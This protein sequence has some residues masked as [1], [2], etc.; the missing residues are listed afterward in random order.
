MQL[1]SAVSAITGVSREKVMLLRH[2]NSTVDLFLA[3][4]GTVEEYTAV[5][6]TGS[7]YDYLDPTKT[8]VEAVAVIV[9]DCVHGVFK[10]HGV[11]KEGT[12]FSL[13]STA[14]RRFDE[15]RGKSER[16][17]RRF[18][19][20]A[21]ATPLIGAPVQGWEKRSRTPVQRSDGG[22]FAEIVVEAHFLKPEEHEIRAQLERSV[23]SALRDSPSARRARM[24]SSPSIPIRIEVV[25]TAFLRNPDVIAE[26]L[27]RAAGVCELCGNPAPFNR[28]SDETPYLEVHHRKTLASGGEDTVE[29]AVATCPN[30]HRREH[31]GYL[32]VQALSEIITGQ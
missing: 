28:R 23:R 10:V 15:A 29:N 32:Y 26:V 8:P 5:Q 13:T 2:S 20:E 18:K 1:A 22:F 31:Y 12:N 4:G 19:L 11:E 6:P 21:F 3:H 24:S 27:L 7:K 9:N 14:H 17:A 30:C 25:A 16:P